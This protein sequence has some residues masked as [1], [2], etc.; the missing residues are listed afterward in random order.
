MV[1]SSTTGYATATIDPTLASDSSGSSGSISPHTQAIIGGVVGGVGG[2]ILIAG[3]AFAAWRIWGRKKGNRLPQDDY[4]AGQEES[5]Q[6]ED[7]TD[8]LERYRIHGETGTQ[9]ATSVNA[10]SN[11]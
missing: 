2:A 1:S 7:N 10:A 5:Y 3:L 11:F 6:K 8:G 4:Y 9:P